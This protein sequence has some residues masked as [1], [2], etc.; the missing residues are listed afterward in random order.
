MEEFTLVLVEEE[1]VACAFPVT[2]V[3]LVEEVCAF[4][5]PLLISLEE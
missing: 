4:T 1:L 5:F 2:C 3:V